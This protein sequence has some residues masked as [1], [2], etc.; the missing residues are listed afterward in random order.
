LVNLSQAL[1]ASTALNA[2]TLFEGSDVR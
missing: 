1:T 2:P